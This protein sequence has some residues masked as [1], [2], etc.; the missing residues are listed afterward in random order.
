MTTLLSLFLR[1][2]RGQGLVEYSLILLFVVLVAF[3]G[4]AAVGSKTNS[5]LLAPAASA[6]P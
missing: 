1:N 6:L 3:I 4:V 2:D 5:T